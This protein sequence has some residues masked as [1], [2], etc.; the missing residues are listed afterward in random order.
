MLVESFHL[1]QEIFPELCGVF[2]NI[3]KPL[4]RIHGKTYVANG[5]MDVMAERWEYHGFM[6][7]AVRYRLG[8]SRWGRWFFTSLA[9]ARSGYPKMGM[10]EFVG[11]LVGTSVS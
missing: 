8:L 4:L 2:E 7:R 11:R 5:V 3:K 9:Q 1:R 10:V 6:I